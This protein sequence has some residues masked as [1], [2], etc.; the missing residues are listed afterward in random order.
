MVQAQWTSVGGGRQELAIWGTAWA[1]LQMQGQPSGVG[2]F[3][4]W[5]KSKPGTGTMVPSAPVNPVSERVL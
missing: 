1:Q 3:P 2:S 5:E 4:S